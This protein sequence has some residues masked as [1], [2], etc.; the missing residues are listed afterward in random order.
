MRY[1]VKVYDM[2]GEYSGI[3]FTP[4]ADSP[5]QAEQKAEW[6]FQEDYSENPNNFQIVAER[7]A[8]EE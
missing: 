1:L 4:E 5:K 6:M 3:S 7:Y 8:I 2:D